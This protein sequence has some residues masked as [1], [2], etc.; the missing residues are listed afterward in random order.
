MLRNK[1][2]HLEIRKRS[3]PWTIEIIVNFQVCHS[4]MKGLPWWSEKSSF[5]VPMPYISINA[6]TGVVYYS[7]KRQIING[8]NHVFFFNSF[9]F[10]FKLF[11]LI[12][13]PEKY[14]KILRFK[15]KTKTKK[16]GRENL[17][18]RTSKRQPHP[19]NCWHVCRK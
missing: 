11:F 9:L 14:C 17:F 6:I 15:N 3:E 4:K 2:Q 18:T 7:D 12:A 5:V 19:K 16:H 8:M 13:N 10:F 1:Y